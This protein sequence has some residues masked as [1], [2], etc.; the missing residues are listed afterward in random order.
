[1]SVR[2]AVGRVEIPTKLLSKNTRL[3]K[4]KGTRFNM[5]KDWPKDVCVLCL[6]A[7]ATT[8]KCPK[9]N[10]KLVLLN[11]DP[12]EADGRNS[13]EWHAPLASHVRFIIPTLRRMRRR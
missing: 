6:N 12:A 2:Y 5:F 4:K 13:V 8:K 7:Y 11:R 1:M 9:G 10:G 3:A